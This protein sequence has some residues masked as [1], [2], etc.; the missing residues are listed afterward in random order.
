MTSEALDNKRAM[1]NLAALSGL[2]AVALFASALATFGTLD[3]EF[4]VFDDY[5]SELGALGKPYGLWWNLTGFLS[6]GLLLAVFGFAYGHVVK[7]RLIGALLMLFGLGFALTAVPIE[8]GDAI[9]GLSTAHILAICLGLAAWMLALARMAHLRTLGG[10]VRLAA[11]VAA[12][13]FLVPFAGQLLQFWTMPLTHRLVFAVVFGWFA[14]TSSRLLLA[15]R[16][17]E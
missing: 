16:Q 10:D 12:G 9:S 15:D 6:V 5:V 2:S 13:L 4:Q 14:W 17:A 11:N 1:R 7:D 3:S 8:D